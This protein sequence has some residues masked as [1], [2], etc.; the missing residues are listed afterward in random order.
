MLSFYNSVRIEN[1]PNRDRL[2][3]DS[4]VQVSLE[5]QI[6]IL[7]GSEQHRGA[8]CRISEECTV[9]DEP[10]IGGRWTRKHS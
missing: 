3:Q 1:P 2:N 6:G 10:A 8:F 4:K 9:V 7:E 5:E